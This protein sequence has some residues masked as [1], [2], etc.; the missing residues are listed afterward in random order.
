MITAY[1]GLAAAD[2]ARIDAYLGLAAADVVRIDAYLGLAAADVVRIDDYL[3]LA[4]ADVTRIDAYLG[5]AAADA[6]RPDAAGLV[7]PGEYLGDAAVADQQLPG[8]VARSDPHEGELHDAA[9]HAVRQ[10]SAVD[11]HAAELVH[12]S[13]ACRYITRLDCRIRF[14]SR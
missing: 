14:N 11:E 13:L 2:V 4:A 3:D 8:D 6:A 10:G 9:A 7:E 1:L 5:L 12:P